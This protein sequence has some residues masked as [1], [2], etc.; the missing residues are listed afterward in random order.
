MSMQDPIANMLTMIRNAQQVNKPDVTMA[1][2]K[3]K[4]AIA[5]ILKEE[6]FIHDFRVTE[7]A[8]KPVL[9][10]ALRYF[11]GKPVIEKIKRV[12]RPGLRVYKGY[13]DLDRVSGYGIRVLS[14]SKGVMSDSAARKLQIGGEVLC[15]VW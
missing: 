2:S 14:T 5:G 1:S 6:G 15:E 12:S 4:V 8:N 10:I 9:N 13:Q 3:L 7:E 11:E